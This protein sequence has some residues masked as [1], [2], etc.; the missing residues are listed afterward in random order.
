MYKRPK[1]VRVEEPP[2]NEKSYYKLWRVYFDYGNGKP[3]LRNMYEEEYLVLMC[4]E[5]LIRKG[6]KA[7]DL[8][9][10]KTLIEDMEKRNIY[11]NSNEEIL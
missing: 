6:Y 10:Y 3:I 2:K 11:D 5:K 8:E 1:I 4:E 7:K 9:K